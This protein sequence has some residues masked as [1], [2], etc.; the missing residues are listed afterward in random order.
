VIRSLFWSLLS[1]SSVEFGS[2]F[3]Y[4]PL[5]LLLQVARSMREVRL[6]VELHYDPPLPLPS[7]VTL[8]YAHRRS[9]FVANLFQLKIHANVSYDILQ[10]HA[11]CAP[12]IRGC[13]APAVHALVGLPESGFSE[14]STIMYHGHITCS[15]MGTWKGWIMPHS[16]HQVSKASGC[17]EHKWIRSTS[18]DPWA[19]T[20]LTSVTDMPSANSLLTFEEAVVWR[21]APGLALQLLV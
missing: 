14:S 2:V 17:G 12:G 10:H 1:S 20:S 11:A 3:Q 18:N 19:L 16:T 5:L 21:N 15:H 4:D 9:A 13:V 7:A 8:E 6:L